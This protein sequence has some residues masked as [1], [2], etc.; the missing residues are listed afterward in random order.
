MG[1]AVVG[2]FTVVISYVAYKYFA[3]RPRLPGGEAAVGGGDAAAT[4][5]E[6]Q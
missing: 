5:G 4:G 3:F 1:Q 6:P 2:V